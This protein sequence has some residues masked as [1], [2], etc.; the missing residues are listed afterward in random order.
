MFK[1]TVFY[2]LLYKVSELCKQYTQEHKKLNATQ[3][4]R[5][6]DKAGVFLLCR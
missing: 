2:R 4:L 1:K 6:R 5:K 3:S